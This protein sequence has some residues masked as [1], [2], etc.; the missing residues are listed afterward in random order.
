MITATYLSNDILN[1][2]MV[3]SEFETSKNLIRTIDSEIEDLLF[4][5]GSSSV[6]QASFTNILPG[7]N[8]SGQNLTI[9]VEDGAPSQIRLNKSIQMNTLTFTGRRTIGGV[10]D[11]ELQGG[12]YLLSPLSNSSLGRIRISKPDKLQV[13]LDYSRI[14]YS[15]TGKIFLINNQTGEY[16]LHNTV[17]LVCVELNFGEFS[18][19]ESSVIMIQNSR[20]EEPITL[21]LEGDFTITVETPINTEYVSLSD[22]GGDPSIPTVLNLYQ[23]SIDVSVI[24]G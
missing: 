6:I 1:A 10:Y 8:R 19:A 7:Y 23:I 12:S 5:P 16:S 24:G 9:L 11:Y 20:R 2:Q 21:D 22:I 14:Q 17:E 15:L 13:T 4:K 18:S 3:E